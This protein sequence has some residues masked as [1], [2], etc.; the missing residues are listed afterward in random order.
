[1]IYQ[2]L[3]NGWMFS[4]LVH[5]MSENKNI[6]ITI[7]LSLTRCLR[8]KFTVVDQNTKPFNSKLHTDKTQKSLNQ[9]LFAALKIS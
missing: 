4:C 9:Q 7:S 5:K 8:C 2:L 3:R 1:M 6:P